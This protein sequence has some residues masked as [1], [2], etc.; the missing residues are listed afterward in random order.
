MI[1]VNYELYSIE[2]HQ[3]LKFSNVILSF[4]IIQ[5]EIKMNFVTFPS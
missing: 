3:M 1:T 2:I 4:L 5:N